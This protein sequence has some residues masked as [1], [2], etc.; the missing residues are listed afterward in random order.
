MGSTGS[1]PSHMAGDCPAV[2]RPRHRH[3]ATKPSPSAPSGDRVLHPSALGCRTHRSLC[4]HAGLFAAA[5]LP[6]RRRDLCWLQIS[7]WSQLDLFDFCWWLLGRGSARRDFDLEF[8]PIPIRATEPLITTLRPLRLKQQQKQT[9]N[10]VEDGLF[11]SSALQSAAYFVHVLRDCGRGAFWP[12]KPLVLPPDLAATASDSA[13]GRCPWAGGTLPSPT[14]PAHH[15]PVPKGCSKDHPLVPRWLQATNTR[16][17][18]PGA[19]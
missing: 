5:A 1:D 11:F 9:Q 16:G 12:T 19:H 13:P 6:Y 15:P 3:V 17:Y 7:G 8:K 2:T 18:G 4:F 14:A 10:L